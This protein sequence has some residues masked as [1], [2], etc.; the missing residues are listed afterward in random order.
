[1]SAQERVTIRLAEAAE[2]EQVAAAINQA[3]ATNGWL[4]TWTH[5][6]ARAEAPAFAVVAEWNF[7]VV[8]G[9]EAATCG[10]SM[11]LG[12]IGVIPTSRRRGIASRILAFA[13][14]EALRRRCDTLECASIEELPITAMF[15]NAGFRAAAREMV[16]GGGCVR[17]PF[18]RLRFV[19]RLA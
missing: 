18:C 14:A 17:R 13:E 9:V 10:R 2:M 16:A 8:G 5:N 3:M 11:K 4:F 6:A 15:L 19:K 12:P 7:Q 1:M